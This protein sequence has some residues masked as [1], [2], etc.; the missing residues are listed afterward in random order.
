MTDIKRKIHVLGINSFKFKDLPF[1]LQNLFIETVNI[2]VPKA[3]FKEIKSWSENNLKQK[4]LF[5]DV[6]LCSSAIRTKE[7]LEIIRHSHHTGFGKINY[8][9]DLYHASDEVMKKI[10]KEHD[11][12]SILLVSH[13]PG[14]SSL[15]SYLSNIVNYDY[16][17]CVF[18]GFE[19]KSKSLNKN[20]KTMYIIRPKKGEILSLLK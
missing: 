1:K 3:Y 16:P 14:I 15:I 8:R 4:K 5:F 9:D 13:N 19:I 7:T 10:I 20:I 17:T 6:T 2:A 18:A 11:A 12:P